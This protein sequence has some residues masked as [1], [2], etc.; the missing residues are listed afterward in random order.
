MR[1]T[2]QR[3]AHPFS[4]NLPSQIPSCRSLYSSRLKQLHH[5]PHIFLMIQTIRQITNSVPSN[6]YPNM[7]SP[8]SIQSPFKG[9]SQFSPVSR[10]RSVPFRTRL[11]GDKISNQFDRSIKQLGAMPAPDKRRYRSS[12]IR[13]KTTRSSSD[14]RDRSLSRGQELSQRAAEERGC[15]FFLNFGGCVGPSAGFSMRDRTRLPFAFSAP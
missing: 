14:F 7:E 2:P 4:L 5:G 3:T 1:Q 12:G 9:L 10:T 6:P 8:S 13:T 15:N 11:S